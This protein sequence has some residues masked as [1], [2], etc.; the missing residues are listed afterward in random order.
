[1]ET[2]SNRYRSHAERQASTRS[3]PYLAKKCGR[4]SVGVVPCN[5]SASS[6]VDSV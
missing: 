2:D 5:G 4:G 3:V 1:M 6:D